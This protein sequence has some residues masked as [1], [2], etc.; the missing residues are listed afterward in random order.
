M[1]T[2]AEEPVDEVE[3]P[4]QPRQPSDEL[5]V[6][7]LFK[8]G[9]AMVGIQSPNCDPVFSTFEGDLDA[10]LSQVPAL[11][12]SA[13]AQWNAHPRNP[14]ANLPEPPP[15]PTP[16]RTATTRSQPSFF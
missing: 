11:V 13:N 8:S 7:I 5:K 10:A 1:V 12:E 4:D 6:V 9:R 16:A 14:K 15:S 2:E 3:E